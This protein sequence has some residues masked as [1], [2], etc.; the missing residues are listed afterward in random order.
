MLLLLLLLLATGRA[1]PGDSY[2]QC[3]LEI[4]VYGATGERLDFRV[5]T[6]T[7]E[8]ERVDLLTAKEQEF[9]VMV[10]GDRLYFPK[11]LIGKRPL[12]ITVADR[13]GIR[14]TRT[15]ALTD[16]EQRMSFE[17]GEQDSGADVGWQTVRGRISGCKLVGEWWIRAMPMFGGHEGPTFEGYIRPAD[18]SFS[19]SC[20]RGERHIIIIGKGQQPIKTFGTNVIGGGKN[21]IGTVDLSGLCPK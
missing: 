1:E 9:R 2:P 17:H 8:R 18:G 12:D 21:D 14:M 10:R 15:V 13:K 3:F 19:L 16:C 7:P 4:P 5:V 6:V 11:S 20:S